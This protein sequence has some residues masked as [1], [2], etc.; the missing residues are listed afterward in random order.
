MTEKIYIVNTICIIAFLIVL[1]VISRKNPI[2]INLTWCIG[3]INTP[4]LTMVSGDK[5]IARHIDML[6]VKQNNIYKQYSLFLA[7]YFILINIVIILSKY[8]ILNRFMLNDIFL[9]LLLVF[10]ETALAGILERN[11]RI[12]GWQTKQELWKNPRKYILPLVV[13]I[14]VSIY[15][16]TLQFL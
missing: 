5:W 13:F 9:A 11:Y 8:A 14:Y 16:T 6:P 4:F 12:K 1:C 15:Y 2:M 10:L 3:S 7:G